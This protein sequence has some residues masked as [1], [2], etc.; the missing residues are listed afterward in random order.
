NLNPNTTYYV[1]AYAT[2]EAGT[3]YGNE[4]Q[5]ISLI[6]GIQSADKD[7]FISVYPNPVSNELMIEY[8]GNKEI[9]SF[10]IL[11]K[12]G[13]IILKGNLVE[14]TTIETSNFPLGIY[15]IRFNMGKTYVV[16]KLIKQ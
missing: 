15:L 14:R 16:K 5:F 9:V 7:K 12:L 1:R 4:E 3:A 13:Q 10:E 11:N 2:N 8:T 6:T